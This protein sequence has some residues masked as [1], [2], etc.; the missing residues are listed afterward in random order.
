METVDPESLEAARRRG[1]NQGMSSALCFLAVAATLWTVF[2]ILKW[3]PVFRDVFVQVHVEM[4][5]LTV[6]VIKHYI[7]ISVF[8]FLSCGIAVFATVTRGDRPVALYLN[9]AAFTIA[10]SWLGLCTVAM[11]LPLMSLLEGIGTRHR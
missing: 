11:F 3:I 4:P 1:F 7:V 6:L 10:M 8:A 2:A 5:A 9:V